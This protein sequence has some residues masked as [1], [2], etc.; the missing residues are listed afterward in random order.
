M[1]TMFPL[2]HARDK[3]ET[4]SVEAR[5]KKKTAGKI[6]N[7]R[8]MGELSEKA[9]RLMHALRRGVEWTGKSLLSLSRFK[10]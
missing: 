8:S 10:K 9:A 3:R 4:G 6:L 5:N 2:F 7:M 1:S